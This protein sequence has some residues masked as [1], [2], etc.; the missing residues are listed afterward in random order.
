EQQQPHPWSRAGACPQ[1]RPLR[2]PGGIVHHDDLGGRPILGQQGFHAA[3]GGRSPFPRDDD[4]RG[5][6]H[7]ASGRTS[8]AVASTSRRRA[9]TATALNRSSMWARAAAPRRA[10]SAGSSSRR[11]TAAASASGSPAGHTRQWRPG[12]ST[13]RNAGPSRVTRGRPAAAV[14]YTLFGTTIAAL[15]PV[16]KTPSVTAADA[17]S[18]GR[19][20]RGDQARQKKRPP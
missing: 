16:P 4:G 3:L 18:A 12:S 6:H 1:A 2:L 11:S 8:R 15:R 13:S 5:T 17:R 14:W 20:A 19:S 7:A 10:A 9:A